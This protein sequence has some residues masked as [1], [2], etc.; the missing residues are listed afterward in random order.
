MKS[1]ILIKKITP[2]ALDD[3]YSFFKKNLPGLFPEYNKREIKF[4]LNNRWGWSKKRYSELLKDEDRI[5]LAAYDGKKIVGTLDAEP[6]VTGLSECEWIMVASGYQGQGIGR[7][8]LKE[9]EKVL[10]KMG[11]HIIF[12]DDPEGRARSFYLK[13]G[14]KKTGYIPKGWLGKDAYIFTKLI[15]NP[16]PKNYLK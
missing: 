5:I 9:Y 14:F 11:G 10:K 1:K 8:L 12:V 15:Q 2:R 6:P 4:I 3:F 13:N 16:K 7:R